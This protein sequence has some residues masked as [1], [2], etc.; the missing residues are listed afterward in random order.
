[1]TA[2]DVQPLL[3][4]LAANPNWVLFSLFLIAFVESLALAGII[5]PGVLL[6]FLVAALAGNLDFPLSQALIAGF[7]GAVLGDGISFYLGHF[8]RDKLRTVW[9]FSRYPKALQQGEAFFTKHGGKSVVIGRF[10]GPIRPVI[11]LVAGMLGMS[12]RRFLIFNVLSAIAWAPAY[13]LPGYLAGAAAGKVLPDRFYPVMLSLLLAL[14]LFVVLFRHVHRR[15]QPGSE[16]YDALEIR[17]QHSRL[18][19]R[20]WIF[21]SRFHEP[22]REF[23]LASLSLFL[24]MALFFVLWSLITLPLQAL[25]GLDHFFLDFALSLRSDWIDPVLIV[26]TL[27]GDEL[28]LYISFTLFVAALSWKRLYVAAIFL[29]SG[30]LL[31][32]LITH[33]FKDLFA[34]SRPDWIAGSLA[35]FA[36]P[37][38]HSSGATIFY[39]LL[40]SFI[41]QGRPPGTRWQIYT[42]L[43]LPIFLIALSR[44]L[45]GV[46]WFSDVIGGISLGL[47]ICALTRV[48]YSRYSTRTLPP[49]VNTKVW[50][51]TSMGTW[52][53]A[54]I[55]YILWRYDS[56]IRLYQLSA[57]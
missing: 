32:A 44:V 16:W 23:P 24:G 5:V 45:L 13:L 33:G 50:L 9:P 12:Q 42:A 36:Y 20:L 35:S 21:F 40:A 43:G 56:A 54:G 29:A 30:G 18:F 51:F 31:T 15:L 53:V 22:P 52:L 4:W 1:M 10:V 28:F 8:F 25:A 2:A 19:R 11:P 41:A 37:S 17:K 47:A 3:D 57:L 27:L 49:G 7:I 48:F 34:V 39:G 26:M 46:H 6:L 14:A 55:V 38:G